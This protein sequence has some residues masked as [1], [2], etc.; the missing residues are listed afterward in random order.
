MT[1][2]Q[3]SGNSVTDSEKKMLVI[4]RLIACDESVKTGSDCP[5]R[6]KCYNDRYKLILQDHVNFKEIHPNVDPVKTLTYTSHGDKICFSALN[7]GGHIRDSL[8]VV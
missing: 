1:Q 5:Y 6:V 2:S 3:R 4:S 7:N 8:S